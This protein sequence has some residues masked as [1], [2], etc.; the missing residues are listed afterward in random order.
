MSPDLPLSTSDDLSYPNE[1]SLTELSTHRLGAFFSFY[2]GS[3]SAVQ[4]DVQVVAHVTCT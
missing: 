1:L 2:D 4:Y 3:D